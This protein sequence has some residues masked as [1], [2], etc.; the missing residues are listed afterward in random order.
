MCAGVRG[1]TE[2]QATA[3]LICRVE[4]TPH[5]VIT[6][7]RLALCEPRGRSGVADGPA[8]QPTI[9]N[10]P[11][12]LCEPVTCQPTLPAVVSACECFVC[13]STACACVQCACG[14]WVDLTPTVSLT[15]VMRVRVC[16]HVDW[17]VAAYPASWQWIPAQAHPLTVPPA[18]RFALY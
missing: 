16:V 12:T 14:C 8:N 11:T 3:D 10:Q 18:L 17:S 15:P 6:P 4:S 5:C 7:N 2:R 1:F 9:H 13:V